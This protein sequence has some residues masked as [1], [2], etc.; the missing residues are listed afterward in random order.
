MAQPDQLLL[1]LD[2]VLHDA[3][4]H[5][6]HFVA[7]VDVRVG[8]VVGGAAVGRPSGVSQAN[9]ALG[10]AVIDSR[11]EAWQLAGGLVDLRLALSIEN[12]Y[13]DAVVPAVFEARQAVRQDRSGLAVTHVPD[14]STHRLSARRV[15]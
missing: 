3:V 6:N 12:G 7:A 15:G 5:D 2:V 11:P 9:T 8:V 4:M 1:E 10:Y 13:P 14:N